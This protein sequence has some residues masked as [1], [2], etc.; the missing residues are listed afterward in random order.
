MQARSGQQYSALEEQFRP[1]GTLEGPP[2]PGTAG[3]LEQQYSPE[4]FTRAAAIPGYEQLAAGAQAQ[5]GAMQRQ[6]QGQ[7]WDSQNIPLA[8]KLELDAASEE[9]KWRQD[10]HVFEWNNPSAAQRAQIGIGYGNLDLQRQQFLSQ[11]IPDGQGGFKPRPADAPPLNFAQQ[12]EVIGAVNMFQ[13]AKNALGDI[14]TIYASGNGGQ[15]LFGMAGGQTAALRDQ[16][17]AALRPIVQKIV[18]GNRTDAPGEADIK[19][20]N[21]F[22]GDV[23]AFGQTSKT[24]ENR[25]KMLEQ[26]VDQQYTPYRR[27][28]GNLMYDAAKSPYA[29]VYGMGEGATPRSQVGKLRPY[30]PSKGE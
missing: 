19:Q 20:I 16:Y 11:N 5:A 18:M 12:Q 30:N 17:Q 26:M 13:N 6:M 29:Q 8:K 24:R 22:L 23:T 10:R 15:S 14:G 27:F 28:G 9:R 1:R 7:V 25:I 21:D 2:A 3:L 4:F